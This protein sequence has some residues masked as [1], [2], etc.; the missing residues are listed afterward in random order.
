MKEW[1]LFQGQGIVYNV[2]NIA[3]QDARM[4]GFVKVENSVVLLANRIF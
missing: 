2:D 3:I 4:F 1:L